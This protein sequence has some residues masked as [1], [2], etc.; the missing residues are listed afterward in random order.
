[1]KS[2]STLKIV[3]LTVT[4]NASG[5]KRVEIYR[6][7]IRVKSCFICNRFIYVV[8]YQPGTLN[9]S[10]QMEK[11]MDVERIDSGDE[12]GMEMDEKPLRETFTP[13]LLFSPSGKIPTEISGNIVYVT[14]AVI[15]TLPNPP[16]RVERSSHVV[17]SVT[18]V[19][20]LFSLQLF[21]SR[22]C[23]SFWPTVC[24]SCS[25]AIRA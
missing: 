19:T 6:K 17:C 2:Y 7:L 16:P 12:Y 8:R 22:F 11:L 3:C 23:A 15:C 13:K 24:R 4:G 18:V 25:T 1:M 21:S 9:S 20:G 14:T 10:S 5:V